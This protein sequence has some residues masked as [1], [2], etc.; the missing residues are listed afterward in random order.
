MM[1]SS[2]VKKSTWIVIAALNEAKRVGSVVRGLRKRGYVHVVV[3]DD[4]STDATSA[5]ARKA[6]ARVVRHVI[7]RGQGA[8]LQTG[9]EFALEHGAKYIVHFDADGQHDADELH[10]LLN[11]L[12]GKKYDVTLGSRFLKRTSDI[13]LKR[14][15][16]LKIAILVNFA[17]YGI[18]MTDAHNGYRAFTRS[19]A[20]KVRITADDAEHASEI[21]E[22]V[23]RHGLRYIEVP[24]T[25]RYSDELIAKGTTSFSKSVRTGL[26]LVIRKFFH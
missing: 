9:M 25:I 19:A 18:K 11:P 4:G 24:V 6:G 13:P 5:I 20:Q 3:V 22:L 8:S 7:N 12:V 21:V 15:I 26:R 17:L 23:K 10:V 16:M 2:D 1:I 14:R